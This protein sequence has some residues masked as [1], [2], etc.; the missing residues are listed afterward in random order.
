M[1]AL[2]GRAY[3]LPEGRRSWAELAPLSI[4]K[5]TGTE[6]GVKEAPLMKKFVPF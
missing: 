2:D 4:C 5:R 3:T 6:G 1:S